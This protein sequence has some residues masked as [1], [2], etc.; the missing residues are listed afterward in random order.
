LTSTDPAGKWRLLASA[1]LLHV[2]SSI[3]PISD[4]IKT[5]S[6]Q[7]WLHGMAK[8]TFPW[9][10]VLHNPTLKRFNVCHAKIILKKHVMKEK[11][12]TK[13]FYNCI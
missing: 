5:R 9:I 1:K 10:P 8:I 7:A 4:A 6:G 2:L 12:P 3:S 11:S 13:P